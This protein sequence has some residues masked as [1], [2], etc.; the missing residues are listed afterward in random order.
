LFVFHA[1]DE[2]STVPDITED[3]IREL[4]ERV[5]SLE[6]ERAIIDVLYACSHGLDGKDYEIFMACYT[7]DGRFAW[8]PEPDGEFV[9]DARGT[10]QLDRF[11]RNL[12]VSVPA[13]IEH[14]ALTNPRIVVNDGLTASAVSWYLIARN[15]GGRPG[16]RSTGRYLDELVRGEDG[17][18]RIRERLALGDMPR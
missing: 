16:V 10:E 2:E 15:Y 1:S 9:V 12:E 4:R 6:D 13:G 3:E 18:W 8:K 5:R 14:H 7:D 11:Y 17:R